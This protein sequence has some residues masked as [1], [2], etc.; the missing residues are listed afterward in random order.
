MPALL[1]PNYDE[2][3]VGYADRSALIDGRF[4][5][6]LPA[7][8]SNV[9]FNHT[10]VVSGQVVGTWTRAQSARAVHVTLSPFRRLRRDEAACVR[11]A[12]RRFGEF[13]ERTVTVT[14]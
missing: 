13:V 12:A 10:I 1:L 7:S 9:I 2:Y 5:K 3:L 11:E 4:T 8:R 6:R 14:L